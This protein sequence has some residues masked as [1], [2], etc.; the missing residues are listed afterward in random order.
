MVQWIRTVPNPAPSSGLRLWGGPKHMTHPTLAQP[1]ATWGRMRLGRHVAILHCKGSSLTLQACNCRERQ[2]GAFQWKV[3]A[4][5]SAF[6]QLC[7][8]VNPPLS[9][10]PLGTCRLYLV[11]N[12]ALPSPS[13]YL[14]V[15]SRDRCY[16]PACSSSNIG[17]SIR[18][19]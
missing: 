16:T 13:L 4:S 8:E 17:V 15:R 3:A 12:L 1:F 19:V 6:A 10:G 7:K 18:D 2:M 9:L 11:E 14:C 5:K